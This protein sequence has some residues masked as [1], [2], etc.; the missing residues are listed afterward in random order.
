MVLKEF[1]KES[2]KFDATPLS[3]RLAFQRAGLEVGLRVLAE[4]RSTIKDARSREGKNRG[5]YSR[6]VADVKKFEESLS[7]AAVFRGTDAEDALVRLW[8]LAVDAG[9]REL[10]RL[11]EE[12]KEQQE[13]SRGSGGSSGR[14]GSRTGLVAQR[15]MDELKRLREETEQTVQMY[16]FRRFDYGFRIEDPD[17]AE[18]A[19]KSE[20][21]T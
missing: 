8:K 6:T 17:I 9:I 10:Q 5:E 18:L 3:E 21:K 20:S 19:E 11:Q 1:E 14:R 12:E 16:M 4:A 13:Q 15:E 7:A 2:Y